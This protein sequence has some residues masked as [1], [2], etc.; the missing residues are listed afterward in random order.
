MEDHSDDIKRW[1]IRRGVPHFI[2]GYAPTTDIWTR[3]SP[4]LLIA[5][6]AG[7]F[8]ALDLQHWSL[9]KNLLASAAVALVLAAG[10]AITNVARRRS[11]FARPD[12]IGVP[13]LATFVIGP[14]VPSAIFTQWGDVA[15]SIIEGLIILAII[16]VLTSYAVFALLGWAIRRSAAQFG[17]LL[18]LVARALP[19]LLLF[20]AFIFMSTEI[21]QVAGTS[22]GPVYPLTLSIFFLLGT[23]FVL[24]R[25]PM[26]TRGLST[27]DD[28]ATVQALVAD[29]PASDIVG[30]PEDGV[31]AAAPLS[32]RQRLNVAMVAVFSQSLQITF[33]SLLLSA[34]YVVFG[35]L[36]ISETTAA[37]WTGLHDVHVL[38]TWHFGGRTLVITEPLLRVA[39]FLGAFTGMY[40]T[41][42]LSTDATYRDEFAEDVGPE[43]RQALAVRVAYLWHRAHPGMRSDDHPE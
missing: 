21:W 39:G 2:D 15:K 16:F 29:T 20:T 23:V 3:S 5:Y 38:L 27:F 34:F 9:R 28:W 42:V 7:G 41:V 37:L 26:L 31:P 13:E 10:W 30:L 19:L 25:I 8:N 4:L 33:V 17:S 18:G 35:L 24:S 43:I 14:A 11:F 6:I 36:A 12:V 22:V 40:F 1:L 32:R